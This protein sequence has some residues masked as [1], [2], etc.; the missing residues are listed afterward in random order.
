LKRIN[1]RPADADARDETDAGE[2]FAR[3]P[4]NARRFGTQ[5]HWSSRI[6]G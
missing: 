1:E 3:Q 4:R 2:H 5:P 6:A